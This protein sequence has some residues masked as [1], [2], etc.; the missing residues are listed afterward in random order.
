MELIDGNLTAQNVLAELKAEVAELA[1]RGVVPHIVVLRVGNDPASISYVNKKEK[2]A[3]EIG[4]KGTV[5]L[6]PETI[7]QAELEAEIDALNAD[8]SV[9]GVLVQAPLPPHIDATAIFNRVSPDKDVDG[10][11]TTNIGRLV[12]ELPNAFAACTPAGILELLARAGVKTAG[13]HAV[14]VGRSLIVGKPVSLLLHSKKSDATVTICHSRTKNL[15]AIA[16][17]ADILIAAIG[18]PKFIT[19]DMVK[20]G[21]VVID[22]GINRVP[23]ATK[24]SGYRLVGDV[25]FENVAPKCS[26]ITPVPGGVGPMTVAM[27]MKNTLAAARRAMNGNA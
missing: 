19:A 3:R 16:R 13:K 25:D 6:F 14:V 21:A 23:D 17:E 18:R 27:L 4:M 15:P 8:A 11:S 7:S 26:F 5:K 22:V 1:A 24:K 20:P 9:H 2:T 12:Q 10:F